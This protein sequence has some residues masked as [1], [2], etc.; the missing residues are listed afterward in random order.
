MAFA[1]SAAATA[2]G[3]VC[4]RGVAMRQRI[5]GRSPSDAGAIVADGLVL[6]CAM[7]D[8]QYPSALTVREQRARDLHLPSLDANRHGTE[9]QFGGT[10]PRSSASH[11]WD[12][13]EF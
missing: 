11:A 4:S 3:N 9:P 10:R 8:G 5:P 13:V 1:S 2:L 6:A 7:P 12:G